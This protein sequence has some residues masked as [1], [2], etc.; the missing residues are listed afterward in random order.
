[1][2]NIVNEYYEDYDDNEYMI[3]HQKISKNRPNWK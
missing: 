2:K 1:M 3:N